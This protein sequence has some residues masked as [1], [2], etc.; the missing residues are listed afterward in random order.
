[1]AGSLLRAVELSEL[2]TDSLADYEALAVRLA[3]EPGLLASLKRRLADRRDSLPLF[4]LP[5]FT[6]C[7]EVALPNMVDRYGAHQ[8]PEGFRS[9]PRHSER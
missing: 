3:T 4:D 9:A 2:I 6:M 5:K 8:S 1:M 7:P